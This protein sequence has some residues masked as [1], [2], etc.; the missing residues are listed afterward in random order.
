MSFSKKTGTAEGIPCVAKEGRQEGSGCQRK[1]GQQRA[2]HVLPWKG[3]RKVEDAKG[4]RDSRGHSKC[5]LGRETG[6]QWMPKKTG[7]AEGIPC[8]A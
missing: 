8:V 2:S 5:C 6:R 1:Q 7:T 3:D 4:D